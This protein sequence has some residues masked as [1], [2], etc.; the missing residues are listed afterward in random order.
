MNIGVLVCGHTPDTLDA[1]PTLISRLLNGQGFT[2]SSYFVVDGELS[3]YEPDEDDPVP[4][5]REDDHPS[6]GE[7]AEQPS[8][9]DNWS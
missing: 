5:T 7:P 2:F 4:A 1:Y 9:E 8:T 3:L 6:T